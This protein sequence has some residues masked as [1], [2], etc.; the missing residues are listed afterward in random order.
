MID[1]VSA[2]DAFDLSSV[3]TSEKISVIGSSLAP[4]VGAVKVGDAAV[5]SDN[6]T[7]VPVSSVCVHA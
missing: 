2:A 3:T 6:T 1:T 5:A 7:V 4:S